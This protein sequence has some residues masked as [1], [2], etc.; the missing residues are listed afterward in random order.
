MFSKTIDK[1]KEFGNEV[2]ILITSKNVI[3]LFFKK[4]NKFPL[5]F[6]EKISKKMVYIINIKTV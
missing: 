6:E 4:S 1:L 2:D 5:L 3:E